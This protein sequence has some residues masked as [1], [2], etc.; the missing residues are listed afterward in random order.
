MFE[1]QVF[2]L[3]R[4]LIYIGL[5]GAYLP[6]SISSQPTTLLGSSFGLPNINAT[7]DY[8]VQDPR[9]IGHVTS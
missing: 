4:R 9:S 7:F 6:E 2:A 8:V 1:W 3:L 5:V